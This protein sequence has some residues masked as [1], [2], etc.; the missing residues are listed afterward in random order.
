VAGHRCVPR[1]CTSPEGQRDT[2]SV[3]SQSVAAQV[4]TL[5][6]RLQILRQGTSATGHESG[7]R[8]VAPLMRSPL[9]LTDETAGSMY[10]FCQSYEISDPDIG[11]SAYPA[12]YAGIP[13]QLLL[14]S[15][16]RKGVFKCMMVG[17]WSGRVSESEPGFIGYFSSSTTKRP[18]EDIALLITSALESRTV[19]TVFNES[20][21]ASIRH[22]LN[23]ER[24]FSHNWSNGNRIY[25]EICL[26]VTGRC[27]HCYKEELS[28][29]PDFSTLIP[30]PG[31]TRSW[32]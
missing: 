31:P 1:R 27:R 5:Q 29:A 22:G 12:E 28:A 13:I 8:E 23:A 16:I 2:S 6:A 15:P 9:V 3:L 26:L 20:M 24:A 17:H 14:G 30:D 21:C 19:D 18:D 10:K 25:E 7:G 11:W 32:R 4:A